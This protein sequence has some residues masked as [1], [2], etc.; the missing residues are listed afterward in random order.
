MSLNH[1]AHTRVSIWEHI[2][3]HNYWRKSCRHTLFVD[4]NDPSPLT[5]LSSS[6]FSTSLKTG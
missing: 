6:K 2:Q 1:H 5:V 3:A 4:P